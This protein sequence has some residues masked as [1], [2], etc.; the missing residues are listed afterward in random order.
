MRKTLYL[1]LI[2]SVFISEDILS[3][4]N[5]SGANAETGI[6]FL[7][8]TGYDDA[9]EW[10]FFCTEGNNSGKWTTI[11]V[12]SCW[13]LQGFGTYQYGMPFYGRENPP[14]I[15]KEKGLYKYKFKLPKEWEGRVVRIVFDGVMTDCE[16]KIND[17]RCG[18]L[19]Q[20]A[21]YRFKS[22]VSDRIFFGDKENV[23]EVTV[24]KESAN[25]SVNMAERRGDYWNFGGIFRP[26]FVEALPAQFI[27]RTAINAKAD[28]DFYADVFLCVAMG[29]NTKVLAELTDIDGKTIGKTIEV[30]V[31]GGTDKAVVRGKFE[32]IK[33]WTP[34]T[35]NL[36]YVT[37]SLVQ[38]GKVLHKT[39]ERFGF[40]TIEIRESDGIYVNGQKVNIRG[41]NRHSFRPETGRTLSKKANYDDVKIIKEMN[42][43]AVRLSHYPSDPDFLDACDELGLYVMVELGGWHHKYDTSV[44][45]KLVHEM[46]KRDVN[47]PCVTWWSNGNEGGHNH[48]LVK[49]YGPLDPQKR[50]VLHPQKNFNGFETMHYRSYGESQEYMRKPEIFMPTEFLHALYD[51]GAGAGLWDY[52]E[53]MRKHPRCAGGFIW[54]FADEGVARTD[55]NGRIDNVGNYG[56]DGI[57][58]PHHEKEGSFYTVRQVWSPVQVMN[59]KLDDDFNGAFTIENR[60]DF[61]NLKDCRFVWTL[62][63]IKDD[64]ASVVKSGEVKGLDLAPHATGILNINLP[65]NW[66][67]ANVLY[68][69]AYGPQGEELWTWDWTWKKADAFYTLTKG[70]TSVSAREEGDNLLITA[71]NTSLTFDKKNG[72]LASVKKN[73]KTISFGNG[74]RFVAFRRGDRSMDVYYNHDDNSARSKERIYEDISGENR[75]TKFDYKAA[76]DSIE[77]TAD[78]FGNMR[79]AHWVINSDGTIRLDYAYQYEGVVELMGVMFDYP[80]DKVQSKK[81]L[82]NGPYR[83]W[84]NRLHGTT[85]GIWENDYNDPIPGESFLYPE[86]KGYFSNWKWAALNTSEGVINLKNTNESDYLGVYSPRDGRDVLLY[87]FPNSG[88]SVLKVIPAVRNKVNATDLVGPSSQAQWVTGLQK[89]SIYLDFEA[90]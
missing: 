18:Y 68:L 72:M 2:L 86:F 44:G 36:Y 25:T 13:E 37:F 5:N 80:E 76:G 48:E 74:P 84:Q 38:D 60:Y 81:W 54:M 51:G 62:K 82:G 67:D 73:N 59:T 75:L 43:N 24:S 10:E 35:P 65:S 4:R 39:K 20:G 79:Q 27:D 30:P 58:G 64:K 9:V 87:T 40:R 7:S 53:M 77:V 83:V 1:L 32:D 16:A 69:S 21:F 22:D 46:V 50:V 56:A 70:N 29:N 52:W 33:N 63:T 57:L 71:G 8:G 17:R 31:S 85:F 49:E 3:Q 23:L 11:P 66:K 89:G 28:G 15:A 12:P 41:V 34:E 19:H 55:Q 47:H 78:Y 61:T 90:K 14:G 6:Q 88:I 45:T 42:M 26:V